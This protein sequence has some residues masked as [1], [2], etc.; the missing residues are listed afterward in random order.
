[1]ELLILQL[2]S[3]AALSLQW[4]AAVTNQCLSEGQSFKHFP[5]G[6]YGSLIDL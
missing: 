1:M 5:E 4:L 6:R 3:S 2:S